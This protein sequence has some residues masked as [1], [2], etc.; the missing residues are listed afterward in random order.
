[1]S[2]VSSC[3]DNQDLGHKAYEAQ[4][5]ITNAQTSSIKVKLHIFIEKM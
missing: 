5:L 2:S 4:N 1:M 3:W